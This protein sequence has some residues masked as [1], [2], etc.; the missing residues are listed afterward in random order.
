MTTPTAIRRYIFGKGIVDRDRIKEKTSPDNGPGR[1]D[2][3]LR[4][5]TGNGIEALGLHITQNED[6]PD[7]TIGIEGKIE[8]GQRF[9]GSFDTRTGAGPID[10]TES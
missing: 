7:G 4:F 3:V 5:R 8:T 2:G 1:A 9:K 6:K 10:I